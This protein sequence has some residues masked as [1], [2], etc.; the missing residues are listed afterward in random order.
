MV[1]RIL[2][3]GASVIGMAVATLALRRIAQAQES[4]FSKAQLKVGKVSGNV[5]MIPRTNGQ[6][7]HN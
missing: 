3:T 6:L 2:R 5:S 7:M 4:N 1:R